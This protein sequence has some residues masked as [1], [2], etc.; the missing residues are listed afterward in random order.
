MSFEWFV[1]SFHNLH[2]ETKLLE[3]MGWDEEKLEAFVKDVE[4]DLQFYEHLDLE[5]F[6]ESL[7]EKGRKYVDEY[8]FDEFKVFMKESIDKILVDLIAQE[9]NLLEN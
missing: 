2:W 8:Y 5:V 6:S 3:M 4:K 9:T 7:I 1:N